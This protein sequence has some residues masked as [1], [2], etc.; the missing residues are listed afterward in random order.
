MHLRLGDMLTNILIASAEAVPFA[1][2]G[3]MADVVGSLPTA[4][5]N[6]GVDTR[7]ILPGYGQIK[8]F[9]FN[10]SHLF[11]FQF[12]HRQGTSD[13]RVYSTVY[14]GVP[15]YFVQAWPYFGTESTVYTD[16]SWDVPRFT[17][18]NQVVMAAVYEIS[19]RLDWF[20]DL[21]HVNDWHTGLIPFLVAER[22]WDETW[23]GVATMMSIHNLAYQGGYAGPFLSQAGLPPRDHWHLTDLNL[24]D[25][26]MAIGIAYSDAVTTV[27]PRYA[28][29]IQYPYMGYSLDPLIRRRAADLHGILNGIDDDI[30]DP[31]TD[32]KL[33]SKYNWENFREK[34]PANKAQ[35]QK[36]MG[37]PERE[38][39]MMI[40][41][42]SR[43]VWQKGVD[44]LAPAI[45]RLFE[46][47]APIQFVAL[48][49]GEADLEAMMRQ[50]GDAYAHKGARI[51]LQYNDAAAQHIY[52]GSDLFLMPSHFEPC[53]MGQMMAMRY[54]SLPLVRETGGLADTV[55]NY[56]D[57][58]ADRGT[59]FVF[60]WEES[61]A[62]Y[63][64]LRW[65]LRTFQNRKDSWQRMQERGMRR[66]FSWTRSAQQYVDLYEYAIRRKRG[67]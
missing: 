38:D 23:R 1:K 31:E 49:T 64:T 20:P 28:I 55:E 26:L 66:D 59:G 33:K 10:I 60:S 15:Y 39:V 19:K 34:R 29:E 43:L 27:S 46:E 51:M 12:S 9:D 16:W 11:S 56:D 7:V 13:V 67:L 22:H 47:D 24:V 37:L 32:P 62:V 21:V 2:V 17:F 36:N 58:D 54:G 14:Q 5:R 48:G 41:L 6:L 44:L 40:G 35:L 18:F 53:G 42:V 50:I 52:A 4:L 57:G 61:A 25:N 63:Y 8:H 45:S 30:W 3:G 65:A